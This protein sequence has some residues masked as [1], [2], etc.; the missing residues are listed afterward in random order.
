MPMHGLQ[1]ARLANGFSAQEEDADLLLAVRHWLGSF[2]CGCAPRLAIIDHLIVFCHADSA[3]NGVIALA[4]A[5]RIGR[6]FMASDI[7]AFYSRRAA[8]ICS[9]RAHDCSSFRALAVGVFHRSLFCG[10]D[11]VYRLR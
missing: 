9:S 11:W 5:R 10:E 2:S 6:R 8:T 1:R 4:I 3:A 7:E